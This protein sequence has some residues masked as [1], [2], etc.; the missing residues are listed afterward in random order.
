MQEE[1]L[2]VN[3]GKHLRQPLSSRGLQHTP[4]QNAS[5]AFALYTLELGWVGVL[6]PEV[7]IQ[8]E[9]LLVHGADLNYSFVVHRYLLMCSC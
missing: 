7:S 9:W 4:L 5:G 2:W 3:P 6:P 8:S 1:S